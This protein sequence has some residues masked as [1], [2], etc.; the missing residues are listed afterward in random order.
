[1]CFLF[2]FLFD[3]FT[4]GVTISLATEP[5]VYCFTPRYHLARNQLEFS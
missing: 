2:D 3:Y 4:I 5:A 1:M